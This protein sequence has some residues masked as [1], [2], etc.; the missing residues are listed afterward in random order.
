MQIALSNGK[1][2]SV[3]D[4]KPEDI[5]WEDIAEGL[6]KINR[7]NGKTMGAPYSVAQHSLHVCKI[8]SRMTDDP[9]AQ[10]YGL[11]HD[12]HEALGLC[13]IPR[14]VKRALS[15][16]GDMDG[17]KRVQVTLD[18][19]VFVAA[20]LHAQMPTDIAQRVKLA[21]DIAYA[22]EVRD[23]MKAKRHLFGGVPKTTERKIKPWPWAKA[24]NEFLTELRHLLYLTNPNG[25]L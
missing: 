6:S 19:A 24:H 14:P 25:V 3:L 15:S 22:T 12:A 1:L 20:G 23:L 8:V 21:D 9:K 5:D 7:F 2:F 16:L 17:Y 11:L 18:A 13:D 10:L 4:P